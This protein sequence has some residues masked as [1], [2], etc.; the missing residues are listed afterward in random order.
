[1]QKCL[2]FC[3]FNISQKMAIDKLLVDTTLGWKWL[4]VTH[5]LAYYNKELITVAKCFTAH[6]Y[7]ATKLSDTLT[8]CTLI[9]LQPM[10]VTIFSTRDFN[11][12][13]FSSTNCLSFTVTKM[14]NQGPYSQHFIFFVNYEWTQ[15]ARVLHFAR[16][17]R[18]ARVKRFCLLGPFICCKENKVLWI[19]P[20]E[21]YSQPFIFCTYYKWAQ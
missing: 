10:I 19:Q 20:L 7:V 4:T 12:N 13:I 8:N 1:V 15:Q 3:K 6:A 16:M 9:C 11:E 21:L 5:T 17:G 14:E 18:V 2:D